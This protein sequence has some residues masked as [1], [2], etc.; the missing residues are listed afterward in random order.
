MLNPNKVR[1]A[2]GTSIF[3]CVGVLFCYKIYPDLYLTYL[4]H[5]DHSKHY[6]VA[7]PSSSDWAFCALF[8]TATVIA[9]VRK[10]WWSTVP[11]WSLVLI[12][13]GIV[14]VVNPIEDIGVG[15][16]AELVI[17]LPVVIQI[18]VLLRKNYRKGSA[19]L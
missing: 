7:L 5:F 15:E 10:W 3:L 2:I 12:A 16:V 9:L 4:A 17:L 13:I 19:L 6:D 14:F 11:L 18:A 1:S 8:V